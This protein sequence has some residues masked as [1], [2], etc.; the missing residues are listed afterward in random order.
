M[1]PTDNSTGIM[2]MMLDMSK[3]VNYDLYNAI[4]SELFN[5]WEFIG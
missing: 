2:N 1:K 3:K 5:I 4:A